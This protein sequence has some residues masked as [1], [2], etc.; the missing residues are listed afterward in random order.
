MAKRRRRWQ[1]SIS[2][3]TS[4]KQFELGSRARAAGWLASSSP[5][6]I[7][8]DVQYPV[9]DHEALIAAGQQAMTGWQKVGS[10]RPHRHL[11]GNPPS[12]E[13]AELRDGAR[14]HD[15]HRPG[16]DDGLPGRLA[17]TPRIVA[18]KP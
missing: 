8:L 10:R 12:P 14:G 18:S 3:R 9:C 16:L 5:Y 7:A 6:G 13:Q 11:P 4:A 2:K 15:D 1:E 17:R